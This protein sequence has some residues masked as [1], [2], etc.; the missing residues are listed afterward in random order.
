[1]RENRR[2]SHILQIL[3]VLYIV[4]K[5]IYFFDSGNPQICDF[6][7]LI[8]I[9][10][11][12][13]RYKFNRMGYVFL[14]FVS[15]ISIINV[16]NFIFDTDFSYIRS[17]MYQIFNLGALF[18]F[19]VMITERNAKEAIGFAVVV[20]AALQLSLYLFTI[21]NQGTRV[22]LLFNNP[23]QLAFY[24]IMMIVIGY[25]VIKRW[26]LRLFV[27]I[28]FSFLILASL[29]KAGIVSLGFAVVLYL[30]VYL[31]NI[32]LRNHRVSSKKVFIGIVAIIFVSVVMLILDS[33]S[34]ESLSNKFF[35][36]VVARV[37]N[38]GR[39]SDDS[40]RGRGY[41][42]LIEEPQWML[43]GAGEGGYD[44]FEDIFYGEIHSTIA[45]VIFSYGVLGLITY[46]YFFVVSLKGVR[47]NELIIFSMIIMYSLT[48]NTIRSTLLL[49]SL[50][51]INRHLYNRYYILSDEEMKNID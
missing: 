34:N 36:Q 12:L 8:A 7:L 27:F 29:S 13:H 23:N 19:S 48:H 41:T 16:T 33:S 3:V 6:I 32:I 50:V 4:L 45:N 35:D 17:S 10:F 28:V 1:M 24:S 46:L 18:A 22:T 21:N 38:I 40:L 43:F 37:S 49:L 26:T 15:I 20:S 39:D 42:K 11:S 5:P 44:R 51:I 30:F 9:V 31:M 47:R 2:G 14:V 25:F